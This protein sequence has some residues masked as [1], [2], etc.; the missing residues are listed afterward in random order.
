MHLSKIA[1]ACAVGLLLASGVLAQEGPSG[2]PPGQAPATTPPLG[3]VGPMVPSPSTEPAPPPPVPSQYNPGANEIP[4][5]GPSSTAGLT[6]PGQSID[7]AA[8]GVYLPASQPESIYTLTVD[9]LFFKLEHAVPQALIINNFTN[10]SVLNTQDINVGFQTGPRIYA[11]Y[12]TE[13]GTSFDLGY[14]GVYNWGS[15]TQFNG[16][17][18]RV[19]G[20]LGLSA[21][22]FNTANA[23]DY[24]QEGNLNSLELNL[25]FGQPDGWVKYLV[26]LRYFR[27]N[28][29]LALTAANAPNALLPQFPFGR[30]STYSIAAENELFG[31]QAGTRMRRC[32]KWF[33]TT[34]DLKAGIYDNNA[35]Q[36]TQLTDLGD[37]E[38]LRSFNA[39]RPV[40][41]FAAEG[42]L[43]I[44]YN[45]NSQWSIHGG[46]NVV[47]LANVARATDQLDFT[48]TTAVGGT[49]VS[50]D[51]IV[52]RNGALVHG[53]NIGVEVHW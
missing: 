34:L 40:P 37:T 29:N 12:M 17:N 16:G 44:S 10:Q 11:S 43:A 48:T 53:G 19:P 3:I 9:T 18:F 45:I 21:V 30:T 52:F 7:P 8:G 2:Q 36:V 49:N 32:G 23:M 25:A 38:Q 13:E 14:F 4:L 39:T 46:Y 28:E 47:W 1:V 50:G 35:T 24:G 22:D 33:D 20:Q 51:Q 41:C 27:L 42:N 15:H 6:M 31:I 5:I 26:G